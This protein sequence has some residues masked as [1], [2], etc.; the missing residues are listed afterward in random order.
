MPQCDILRPMRLP[1]VLVGDHRLGGISATISAYESLLLRGY[2]VEAVVLMS[3]DRLGNAAAISQHFER[4]AHQLGRT[5]NIVSLPLCLPP[6]GPPPAA[7]QQDPEAVHLDSELLSWLQQSGP[8]FQQLLQHLKARHQQR[9]L[10]L[11]TAEARAKSTVWWP[12]TQHSNLGDGAVTVVDARAGEDWHVYRGPA[13]TSDSTSAAASSSSSS[14]GAA[15]LGGSSGPPMLQPQYDAPSSWWTQM[16]SGQQLQSEVARAVAYAAGRYMHVMFPENA[17]EPALQ[18]SCA[19]SCAVWLCMDVHCVMYH[20][21]VC[22]VVLC[23]CTGRQGQDRSCSPHHATPHGIELHHTHH[24][25][26]PRQP[27]LIWPPCA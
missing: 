7:Q 8:H 23:W 22:E 14:S 16:A 11:Q 20:I 21:L 13:S 17:H 4:A 26:P 6:S 27:H 2:D 15:A 19:K 9:L 3:D 10:Q 18:V 24:P 25:T 1:A 5:T 12:F